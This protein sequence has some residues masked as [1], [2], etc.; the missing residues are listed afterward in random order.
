MNLLPKSLILDNYNREMVCV[1]VRVRER[2]EW[3]EFKFEQWT[4]TTATTTTPPAIRYRRNSAHFQCCIFCRHCAAFLSFRLIRSHSL[5]YLCENSENET[6]YTSVIGVSINNI[7]HC[8]YCIK[9]CIARNLT[10]EYELNSALLP[11]SIAPT[12]NSCM[13]NCCAVMVADRETREER[14]HAIAVNEIAKQKK[15]HS[16]KRQWTNKPE[17]IVNVCVCACTEKQVQR[18]HYCV[19]IYIYVCTW[20]D[21]TLARH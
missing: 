19:C 14:H 20:Y 16:Q 13:S 17:K 8:V 15:T 5:C 6:I 4:L 18:L 21:F 10:T 9:M 11:A 7:S 12:M 2:M 3:C 1:C